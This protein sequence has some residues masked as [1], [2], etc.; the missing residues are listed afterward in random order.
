MY[1]LYVYIHVYVYIYIYIDI[2]HVFMYVCVYV[3]AHVSLDAWMYGCLDAWMVWVN[4]GYP[5]NPMVHAE[6][7]ENITTSVLPEGLNCDR[8]RSIYL[9]I[10]M[11]VYIYIYNDIQIYNIL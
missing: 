8:Y 10:C 9:C 4:I 11:Y 5:K 1:T 7:T 3:G 2:A 6:P